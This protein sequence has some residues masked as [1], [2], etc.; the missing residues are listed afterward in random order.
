[1]KVGSGRIDITPEKPFY[2]LGYKTPL[3]NQ[4]A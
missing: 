1:M 4:P 2:L 3:R